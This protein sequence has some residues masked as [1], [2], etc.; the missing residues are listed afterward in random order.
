MKSILIIPALLVSSIAFGQSYKLTKKEYK[1][2]TSDKRYKEFIQNVPQK[3]Q[4]QVLRYSKC[5][6]KIYKVS[7]K[8]ALFE[9]IGPIDNNHMEICSELTYKR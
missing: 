7:L 4:D 3:N 6:S 2:I 1:S 5:I 8:K 9:D